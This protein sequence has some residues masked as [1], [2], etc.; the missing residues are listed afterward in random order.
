MS[1]RYWDDKMEKSHHHRH[2]DDDRRREYRRRSRSRDRDRDRHRRRRSSSSR[3]RSRSRS[4]Y[5]HHRRH[6]KS[7][8]RSS[9][10]DRKPQ[11][12]DRETHAAQKKEENRPKPASVAS[13]SAE[14]TQDGFD[15]A[16]IQ[17]PEKEIQYIGGVESEE[18][19]KKIHEQMQER[20]RKLKEAEPKP[21]QRTK[22]AC[23][24][25]ATPF[26]NDGSFLEKFKEM[27]ER[28]SQQQETQQ[29]EDDRLRLLP[30]IGRRRGGK[31][32]KTGI[33]EKPKPIEDNT[34]EGGAKDAWSLYLQEVKRYKNATCDPDAPSRSLVK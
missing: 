2:R 21:L 28:F 24:V 12:N 22:P 33:V 23:L 26:A 9:S 11:K 30:M 19:R 4:R 1:G 5:D 10:R 6:H 29:R 27:Q 31:I 7:H 18:E 32:L 15:F 16:S 25:N 14:S 8:R 34:A 13:K 3:S 20:L 17:M